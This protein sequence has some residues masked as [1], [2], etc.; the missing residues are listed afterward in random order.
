MMTITRE[1]GKYCSY[2]K[3]RNLNRIYADIFI[4]VPKHLSDM[5]FITKLTKLG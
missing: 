2:S 5:I 4:Y 1:N 3:K